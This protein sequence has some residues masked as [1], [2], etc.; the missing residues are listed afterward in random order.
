MPSRL[1]D[2]RDALVAR[3]EAIVPETDA[4]RLFAHAANPAVSVTRTGAG[5][6]LGGD[7]GDRNFWF[8]LPTAET[9]NEWGDSVTIRVARFELVF[10]VS[11]TGP[12]LA[13]TW[14]RI[15]NEATQIAREVDRYQVLTGPWP[16]GVQEVVAL[17]WDRPA[18]KGSGYEVSL[19]LEATVEET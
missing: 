17:G 15:V 13:A 14:D 19:R 4:T 8:T 12:D 9:P 16:A 10:R 6:D 3:L 1:V 18:R 5:G 2:V 7:S 11:A